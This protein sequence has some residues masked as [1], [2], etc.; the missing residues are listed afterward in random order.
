MKK[1]IQ[2][3]I[4]TC[5]VS[6]TVAGLSILFGL[7]EAKGFGYVVFGAFYMLLP[8]ACA[9]ILQ[10]MR[11]EKPFSDSFVSFNINWW[12]L[13]AGLVPFVY[14]FMTLGINL[15][16][17]NVSFSPDYEGFLS[18]LPEDQAELAVQQLSKFPPVVFLFIMAVGS[19]FAAYSIN[20]V[21]ALG[22]ELGRTDL[23]EKLRLKDKRN[24]TEN[25]LNPALELGF[26]ERT[27]P[28]KPNSRFQKYRMTEKGKTK[29]FN[30]YDL[31]N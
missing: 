31:K 19:L 9:I 27:I 12:F 20:A 21:F 3:I 28:D 4:L 6:W 17:P 24:F 23:M 18:M 16:F 22:E 15:T 13:V 1:S 14:T 25:Y 29:L 11:K 10:V 26:I 2:F 7:R 30:S 5:A 8:A